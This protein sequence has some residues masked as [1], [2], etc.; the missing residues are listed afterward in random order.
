MTRSGRKGPVGIDVLLTTYDA[1][2]RATTPGGLSFAWTAAKHGNKVGGVCGGLGIEEEYY[3]TSF[4]DDAY[5]S[6]FV[7]IHVS[8]LS[9]NR[10]STAL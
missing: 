1:T 6:P 8:L 7:V 5:G 2:Y 10:S 3:C 9:Y 4:C